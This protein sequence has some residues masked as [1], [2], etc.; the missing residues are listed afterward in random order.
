V[1][2][3]LE[4]LRHVPLFSH[5][6]NDDLDRIARVADSV[7]VE[8]GRVLVSEGDLGREAFIV[9]DAEVEVSLNGKTVATLGPAEPF[10]EMA[11]IDR[12]PRNATVTVTKPGTVLVLGQREFAGLLE[13]PPF[14][15]TILIALANRV[16][17]MDQEYIG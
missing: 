8:P 7:V 13:E 4:S 2:D 5:C 3:Y 9:L 6:S 12:Q 11:L 17:E 10:G 16:R 1:I 14:A 15:R